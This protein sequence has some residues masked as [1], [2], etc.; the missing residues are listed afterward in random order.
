MKEGQALVLGPGSHEPRGARDKLEWGE[1]VPTNRTPSRLPARNYDYGR[2]GAEFK[3]WYTFSELPRG[4]QIG[5]FDLLQPII[6]GIRTIK[7]FLFTLL[8]TNPETGVY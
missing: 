3:I 8:I 5:C 2:R 1:P 4:I 7:R 6:I